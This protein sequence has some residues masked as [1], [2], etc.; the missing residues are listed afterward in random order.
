[1]GQIQLCVGTKIY[2]RELAH[3]IIGAGMSPVSGQDGN[4]GRGAVAVVFK[5]CLEAESLPLKG[6]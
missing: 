3:V 6:P 1:M 5:G 2:L 4:L